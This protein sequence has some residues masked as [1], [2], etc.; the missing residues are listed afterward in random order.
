M[1]IRWRYDME[2]LSASI[3]LGEDDVMVTGASPQKGLVMWSFSDPFVVYLN[4]MLN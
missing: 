1:W 2:I 4:K 3:A